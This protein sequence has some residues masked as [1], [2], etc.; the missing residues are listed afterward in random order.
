GLGDALFHAI[1]IKPHH[2]AVGRDAADVIPL[3]G[4]GNGGADEMLL[5][6]AAVGVMLEDIAGRDAQL[7]RPGTTGATAVRAHQNAA[8]AHRVEFDPGGDRIRGRTNCVHD[9]HVIV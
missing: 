3:A 9:F 7:V 6:H 5:T 4:D 2:A 8:R 1:D